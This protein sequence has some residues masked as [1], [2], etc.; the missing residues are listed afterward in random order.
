MGIERLGWQTN[1]PDLT[2]TGIPLLHRW[3]AG[4]KDVLGRPGLDFSPGDALSLLFFGPRDS[5]LRFHRSFLVARGPDTST[6]PGRS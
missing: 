1:R 3:L 6:W 5:K 2:L 4:A